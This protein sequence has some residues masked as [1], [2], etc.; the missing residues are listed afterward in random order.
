MHFL[1]KLRKFI[2]RLFQKQKRDTFEP[3]RLPCRI[4]A[5]TSAFSRN[6]E[7]TGVDLSLYESDGI[8]HFFVT[9]TM[10]M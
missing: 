4:L 3:I 2:T 5:V 8:G 7:S 6:F 10:S 1:D 9:T